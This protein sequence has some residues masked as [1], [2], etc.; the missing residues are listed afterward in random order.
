MHWVLQV[1]TAADGPGA[2]SEVSG[3]IAVDWLTA[4]ARA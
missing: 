2:D 3:H 1:E 4:Y